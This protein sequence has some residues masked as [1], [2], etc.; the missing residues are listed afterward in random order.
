[1]SDRRSS[2]ERRERDERR[3]AREQRRTS[4]ESHTVIEIAGA[5]LRAVAFSRSGDDAADQVRVMTVR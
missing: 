4:N 5:D 3:R 2:D 1:M